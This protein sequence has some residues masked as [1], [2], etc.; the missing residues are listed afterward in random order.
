MTYYSREIKMPTTRLE[1][2]CNYVQMIINQLEAGQHGEALYTA[3]DLRDTLSG[4]AN[5]FASIT[6]GKDNAMLAEL[7][8]QHAAEMAD[9]IIKAHADGVRDGENAHKKKMV[10]L[11]GLAA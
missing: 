6:A 9:A 2:L 3:A 5:P 7:K 8:R 1:G 4:Q 11:L 10:A